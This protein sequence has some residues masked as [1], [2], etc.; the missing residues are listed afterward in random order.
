M[1]F[2]C[3][4]DA[5]IATD[6]NLADGIATGGKSQSPSQLSHCLGD[7]I[8]QNDVDKGSNG[9]R[10]H[11]ASTVGL[12]KYDVAKAVNLIAIKVLGSNGGGTM[13]DVGG[14]LWAATA[15]VEYTATRKT[16]YKGSVANMSLSDGKSLA[17]DD[18]SIR[19]SSLAYTSLSLLVTTTWMP[20]LIPPLPLRTLSPLVLPL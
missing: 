18:A 12:R 2:D 19:P 14:V 8:P 15:K 20:A 6:C 5:G 16:K 4:P 7:V 17:L 1:Q 9:H 11:C 3:N 10:T 13:A